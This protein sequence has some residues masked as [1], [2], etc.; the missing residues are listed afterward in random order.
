MRVLNCLAAES[1]ALPAGREGCH[2][3]VVTEWEGLSSRQS[4]SPKL[5]SLKCSQQLFK[6][7]T[8]APRP[9]PQVSEWQPPVPPA[10]RP[11]ATVLLPSPLDR[12]RGS[13]SR[14]LG[15]GGC[16]GSGS[17][18]LGPGS[19]PTPGRGT[20]GPPPSTQEQTPRRAPVLLQPFFLSWYVYRSFLAMVPSDSRTSM[21]GRSRQS[22][23][24]ARGMC[25]M[26]AA[27]SAL[28]S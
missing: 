27:T 11:Q 26:R 13:G 18:G 14:G 12:C 16:G 1:Q 20:A 25:R 23:P 22:E 10:R 2:E 4:L 28:M 19:T 9:G 6:A 8:S 7:R 17:R 21:F 15:L 24:G 5:L 3:T